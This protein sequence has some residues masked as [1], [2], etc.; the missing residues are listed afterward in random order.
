VYAFIDNPFIGDDTNGGEPGGNIRTAFLYRSDRVDFVDN[1][2]RTIGVNGV[3]I[4]T[5]GS[6]AA[7]DQQTNVDNPFFGSRPPLVGTFEFNGNQVTVVNNHFT[8]KGGSGAVIG[9]IEPPLNAS[10]VQR[11]AQAQ[12]VNNFV[13]SLLASDAN[14]K[15]MVAGDLNEFPWEEPMS[16]LKGIATI[17]GYDAPASGPFDATATYV[18]GGTAILH[19]LQDT[20]PANEQYDYVFDG[21]AQTLDHMMVTC[22]LA[23]S[24]QFDV[25]RINAEFSD[26]TSDH[27]PLVAAFD[28]PVPTTNYTLQLLHLYGET[29]TIAK[30]TAPIMGAMIDKFDDLYANTLILAEGDTWIPGPWLVAGAD[31]SL[32]AVPG[33]GATA[34]ARPDVA[35]MNAFGV[36]ASALGNHEF[37]LGS[38]IVSGAIVPSGAWVGAQF[39]F[40][41]ANL[42]FSADS[43]LR[44][45]ADASLGGTATNHFAGQEA[46]AIKAKIAPSAVVTM[47]GE[48]IGIVGATTY[49]LLSKT[50]P[51]GT[52]PKDDGNP[53]TDDLQ[54]VAA[55][56]QGAVDALIAQG[57]NKIVMVD[58]LD[59]FERNKLLAPMVTGIDIM[60]AGG[61]HERMGDVNDVPGSFN[62]HS[63]TFVPDAY[64]IVTV[65]SDGKPTLIIT[66][67]T[68]FTYLGRLVAEFDS[69]GE[70]ILGSLNNTVNGAYASNEATLQSVYGSTSTSEQIIDQSVI[71]SKVEAIADAIDAIVSLKDG[72]KFG[73]SDVFLE[74]DRVF[75]RAEE[76]NLG[77]VTADANAW[78]AQ[79][80]MGDVPYLVSLKNGGGLR[81]SIGSIDEDGGKIANP[82]APGAAGNVSQLDVEKSLRFD[83]KLMVFDRRRR[84]GFPGVRRL[85]HDRAR[86][87]IRP[88]GHEHDL[89]F[90]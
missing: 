62:G 20:L 2:L 10:E 58:Q 6:A 80:A 82:V 34:L 61:G 30:D 84:W 60:V 40:I 31:P 77:D 15:V 26:Q 88:D 5:P 64:P 14:A 79:Q 85:R 19:D 7:L 38:P 51:N 57:V 44:G 23:A 55:Y 83:N 54:E 68:E 81:A 28:L 63:P 76:T 16:V 72:N 25:V 43:S 89:L 46:S 37:D 12:A 53:S 33:I 65:G 39:P 73:F 71:G 90:I 47:T 9:S 27:D 87:H 1:S 50:S 13:D 29:G 52:K 11:A 59:T 32:N 56:I 48:K 4:D 70:L 3:S 36:D 66:T 22:S 24:A 74:G 67:D 35:I 86:G 69:N 49:D 18:P 8:S 21:S 78:K 45:L 41:T 75:A 17:T 42:D